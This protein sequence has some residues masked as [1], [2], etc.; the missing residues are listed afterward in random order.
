MEK[1][2]RGSAGE[3]QGGMRRA[4]GTTVKFLI[5]C[6]YSA[7][8]NLMERALAR[9]GGIKPVLEYG[10]L[11]LGRKGL[12]GMRWV[13]LRLRGCYSTGYMEVSIG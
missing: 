6:R 9:Y 5:W 2:G 10:N 11:P 7:V 1:R 12:G 13:E 4:E 3:K 8:L